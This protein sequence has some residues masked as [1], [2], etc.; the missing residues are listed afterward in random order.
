[1]TE[2]AP[3]RDERERDFLAETRLIDS[4]STQ[5][6]SRHE[7]DIALA[8]ELLSSGIIN[9]RAISKAVSDWSIHGSV[10]LADHLCDKGI[11]SRDQIDQLQESAQTRVERLRRR[12]NPRALR[13]RQPQWR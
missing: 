5:A 6:L 4:G 7:E 8:A 11:L 10:P 3:K 13:F 9:E 12:C 1:M 2:K